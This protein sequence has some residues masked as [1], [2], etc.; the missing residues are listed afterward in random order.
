MTLS[1]ATDAFTSAFK[2]STAAALKTSVDNVNQVTYKNSET[3]RQLLAG[4]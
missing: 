2:R 3:R 4:E 1:Q